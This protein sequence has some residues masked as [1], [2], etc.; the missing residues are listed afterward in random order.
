MKKLK[1]KELLAY[2]DVYRSAFPDWQ[3][4]PDAQIS[5]T[6]GPLK[7]QI[8][9]EALLTG[10][11]RLS[12]AVELLLNMPKP[13]HI[14]TCHLDIR[15]RDI[16][17]REHLAKWQSAVK[18]MEEQFVPP[19]RRPLEVAETLRLAELEVE[20]DNIVNMHYSAC[21]AALN[22]SHGNL[23]RAQYWCDRLKQQSTSRGRELPEWAIEKVNFGAELSP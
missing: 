20:R 1:K 19:P 8:G 14:L 4:E 22:A 12:S 11:Y 3:G 16:Y 13:R 10:A 7:Q 18:A 9:M 2:F 15:H 23:T 6:H 17:P 5:R 21:L